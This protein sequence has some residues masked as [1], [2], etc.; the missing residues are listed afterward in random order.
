MLAHDGD[1]DHGEKTDELRKYKYPLPKI[2]EEHTEFPPSST[3]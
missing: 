1:D 2:Q 3:R